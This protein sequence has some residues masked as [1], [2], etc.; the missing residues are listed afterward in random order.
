[1]DKFKLFSSLEAQHNLPS[2]LLDA[3]MMQ[4]SRGNANALSPKGA[5]GYFQ[6]MPA[7]AKQY[8]VNPSDLTSSATGAA[9]MYADLLKKNNGNLDKALA[10]YNW[11]SGNLSRK[12]LDKAPKETRDYI[13]KVKQNMSKSGSMGGAGVEAEEWVVEEPQAQSEEW[14]VEDS[15]Q[16]PMQAEPT[17]SKTEMLMQGVG[18]V[19]AGLVRGAGSIGATLL[20]PFDMVDNATK[21][22][23][24]LNKVWQASN[25]MAALSGISNTGDRRTGMDEGLSSIGADINSLAFKGGKLGGE[26]A[27]TAGAG[28]LL[29]NVVKSASPSLAAAIESGGLSLNGLGSASKLVNGL[30]RTVGGAISGGA[31][32]GLANPDDALTGAG[33]GAIL[34][35]AVK[36]SAFLGG[37]PSKMIKGTLGST[38][39]AGGEAVNQAFKAG[40][41]GKTAF[42]DNMRG[43][44]SFDDV[45][46]QAKQGLSN[47]RMER[48][49]AY[50]SGMVN[51]KGDKSIL[52]F[53]PIEKA[54]N[55]I[56]SLGSFK[57]VQINK[58]ASGVVNEISDTINQWKSLDPAQYHTPEGLDALKQSIGDIRDATQFGTPARKAADTIY[59]SVKDQITK[60][61]PA[62]SK[63]MKDYSDA[64]KTLTELEKSLSLGS[65]AQVD[66]SVRKLQ[67]IMRN[68][69]QT[70]Y[71][72]RLDLVNKLESQGGVD[73]MPALAGQSMNSWMPR[74]MIGAIEKAGAPIA[75]YSNPA[76]AALLP[77]ASPRLVGEAAYKLGGANRLL[78][79]SL[80]YFTGNTGLLGGVNSGYINDIGRY[81]P[82]AILSSQTER[83]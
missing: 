40:R 39:G 13:V 46:G 82:L 63:V 68:N 77:F 17:T 36:T 70:N 49:D 53:A 51:I 81:L 35:T 31:T 37:L 25:P 69:A 33:I 6:F 55:N 4:E 67:S 26:I 43:N 24:I 30:T 73:L 5:Q 80:N 15:P 66:T 42:L 1:M 2:G 34:P 3:V 20:K 27:G 58:N 9:R 76:T 19:G 74:G 18:N 12:G 75:M 11:G 62:Y 38:T 50:R 29:G 79:N 14:I 54:V 7:T 56:Q 23:P 16:Q 83:Q 41:E 47:M 61:A 78:D 64:S 48:A 57:G 52:D 71:G 60:Q 10:G 21:Q 65:K 28:G 44:A 72:N 32:T 22:S 45:V 8:G 59:N